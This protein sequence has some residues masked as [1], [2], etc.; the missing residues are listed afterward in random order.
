MVV[1]VPVLFAV[2]GSEANDAVALSVRVVPPASDALVFT[3]SVNVC[4]AEA[5]AEPEHEM[6]PVAPTEGVV[7]D[8]PPGAARETNV[9]P[10]GKVSVSV[11]A[12]ASLGP[13][14]LTP[15]V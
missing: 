13:L 15:M 3:V 6:L 11:T 7:H 5:G 14:L 12:L 8:Q 4:V 1:A 9:V 10:A 2:L